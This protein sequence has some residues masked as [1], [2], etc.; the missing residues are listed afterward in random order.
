MRLHVKSVGGDLKSANL[1]TNQ[2]ALKKW[3]IIDLELEK[4]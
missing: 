3:H 4:I 2:F 1:L